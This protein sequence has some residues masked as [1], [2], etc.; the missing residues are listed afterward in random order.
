MGLRLLSDN[1]TLHHV[2]RVWEKQARG[3]PLDLADGLVLLQLAQYILLCD[4]VLVSAFDV[5]ATTQLTRE[6]LGRLGQD[7]HTTLDDGTPLIR[8]V[9]FSASE[10]ASACLSAGSAIAQDLA[11]LDDPAIRRL[12][13]LATPITRP[14]TLAS[15]P[16]VKW[17]E[18]PW[19]EAERHALLGSALEERLAVGAYDYVVAA[20]DELYVLLQ[21]VGQ[22]FTGDWQSVAAGL[23][24][25]FRSAINQ[26]LA[27]Q[28]STYYTPAPQRARVAHY[29]DA[30]FVRALDQTVTALASEAGLGLEHDTLGRTW[31]HDH[32]PLPVFALHFLAAQAPADTPNLLEVARSLRNRPDVSAVRQWVTE[33]EGKFAS[34]DFDE[35][36]VAKAEL[37][38]IAREIGL[39]LKTGTQS[40]LTV[41]ASVDIFGK[42]SVST[43]P[44]GLMR[45]ISRRMRWRMRRRRLFI[46][47]VASDLALREVARDVM[48]LING[49]GAAR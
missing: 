13:V 17:L 49:S 48:A 39:R 44:S 11:A 46:A 29:A 42:V 9:S 22:R 21:N 26:E 2:Q 32:L 28:H 4:E 25:L 12:G 19:S 6:V 10:Y 18:R 31:Q 30:S 37:A 38:E 47:T 45:A 41:S 40:V 43:N 16:L 20:N 36:Q 24:V 7:W 23:G 5:P 34:R 33:W 15:P 3:Q 27:A 8:T 1:T 14:I 35:R